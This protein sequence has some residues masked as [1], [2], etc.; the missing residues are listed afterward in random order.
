LGFGLDVDPSTAAQSRPDREA[1]A[2]AERGPPEPVLAGSLRQNLTGYLTAD[3]NHDGLISRAEAQAYYEARFG[4]MDRNRDA[5]LDRAEFVRVPPVTIHDARVLRSG[6]TDSISFE[7][8]DLNGDGV[9]DPEEFQRAA[10]ARR[11][12]D[13]NSRLRDRK[14]RETA[15]DHLDADG[16]GMVGK[17]GF[18]AAGA[19]HFM[20]SD[21]DGDGV[22]SV[23]EFLAAPRL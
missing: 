19:H 23:W 6:R 7:Q 11:D 10:A 2:L 13:P 14:W 5:Q 1:A 17:A 22:V 3:A 8:L 9:L 4:F 21:R 12:P 18:L 20:R 16:D 15:F